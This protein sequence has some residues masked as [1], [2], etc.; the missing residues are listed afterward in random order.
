MNLASRKAHW[1]NVYQTKTITEVGWYQPTPLTS[2]SFIEALD[3]SRDVNIIDVGGGD[4]FLIDYLLKQGYHS[5]S[6]LDISAKAI[7]RAQ[8]RL[9]SDCQNVKWIISDAS[10]FIPEEKYDVWHDRATFHF[11]TD[12]D[13]VQHYLS[14]L[15]QSL[16]AGGYF[17]IGTFST[18]GPKKCSGLDIRQYDTPD[19][20]KLLGPDYKIIKCITPDHITPGGQI[21]HYTFCC[22]QRIRD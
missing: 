9:G 17:I 18:S 8:Q 10:S 11:L 22:F 15:N 5:I 12:D 1:E 19:L 20:V 21:Q 16:K 14:S 7:E 6:V 13:E 3:L 2:I 4:S